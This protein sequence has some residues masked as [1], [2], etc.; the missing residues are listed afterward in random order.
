M[1][2]L[3]IDQITK[4]LNICGTPTNETLNKITSEEVPIE[5]MKVTNAKVVFPLGNL[6]YPLTSK[7]G[8]ERFPECFSRGKPARY[9]I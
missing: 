1:S 3:E 6:I 2:F 9:W 4:V 8:K 7:H 5:S